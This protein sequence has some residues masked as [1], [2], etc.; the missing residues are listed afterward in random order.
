M[1]VE[2]LLENLE[3]F[4]ALLGKTLP[5]H[6]Q[7][8]IL[9]NILLEASNEGGFYLSATDLELGVRVKIPAKIIEE[10]AFTIPGKQFIEIIS[11]LPKDK[12]VLSQEKD[13]VILSA[14][15]NKI[16]F[17][18]IPKEEYPNL[19]EEKG[20]LMYTFQ[21]GEF[22]SIFSHLT[23]AASLD[24]SRPILTGIC[25]IQ[26]E[27]HIDFVATD[28][29]R[30]SLK[31][32]EREKMLKENES[33]VVST[34]LIH[35]VLS[36]KNRSSEFK[37]YVHAGS[38]QVI[39]E[40]D[41]VVLVGRMISGDYPNYERIL[42]QG[43]RTHVVVD[44]EGFLQSIKLA[45]VFAKDAAN[46]I[47]VKI[48]NNVLSMFSRTSGVG[49]GEIRQDIEQEGDDVEISFNVKYLTDFLKNIDQEDIVM[50]LNS[51]LE[52]ALFKGKKEDSFLHIIMPVRV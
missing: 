40:T 41:N 28:G 24:E 12:V 51:S 5:V 26:K 36:L 9:S 4:T 17:Q 45:S 49:E 31:R 18:T 14:R 2:F 1:K 7:L 11:S 46:V 8:P 25:I 48:E 34:K 50:E 22:E 39:F 42:P 16:I 37:M 27:N 10:G 33:M 44:R 43:N 13:S 6:S 32:I 3:G 38:N 29:F 19:F 23:Y 35:E 47:K 52:P 15:D 30:L 21:K 20:T